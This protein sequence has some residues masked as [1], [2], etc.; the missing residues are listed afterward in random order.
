MFFN[1]GESNSKITIETYDLRST[2]NL[3]PTMNNQESNTKQSIDN[4]EYCG[5]KI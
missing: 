1:C 4:I 5:S 2:L 3:L